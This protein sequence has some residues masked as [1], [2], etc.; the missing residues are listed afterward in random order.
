MK[1]RLFK[2][3]FVGLLLPAIVTIAAADDAKNEAIKKDRKK[4][5][6][7]WRIVALV[8]NGNKAKQEDARKLIVVNGSDGTWSL[9]SEDK[10]ISRGTSTID[11]TQNPKT[12]DFTP[13]NGEGNGKLHLGIYEL[14]EETRRLCFAPPGKERPT[15][16]SSA[17]DSGHILV[18]FERVKTK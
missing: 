12:I 2:C 14:G 4:I 7:T 18:T 3:L 11:P 16:F 15:E 6:G 5:E 13:T 8:V 1:N 17:T 10:E 9:R